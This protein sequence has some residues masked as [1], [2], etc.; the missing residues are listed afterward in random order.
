MTDDTSDI[1]EAQYEKRNEPIQRTIDALAQY[2][3]SEIEQHGMK[4]EIA[5]KHGLDADRI[6]YVLN[7]YDDLVRYRRSMMRSPVDPE[8]VKASY[9]DETMRQLA[10]SDGGDAVVSIDF[11][12][13][14]AFR[15]M[16]LLPGDMGLKVYR[17]LLTEDFDRAEL[18]RQLEDI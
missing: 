11:T 14:E 12:L 10:A 5:R 7:R 16:K 8:A 4:A 18:R 17:Q 3:S 15:V 6:H 1:R 2:E 9:E 13:D